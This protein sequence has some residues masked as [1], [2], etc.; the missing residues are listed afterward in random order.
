MNAN[1]KTLLGNLNLFNLESRISSGI[2]NRVVFL[3]K[4]PMRKFDSGL[5]KVRKILEP[6]IISAKYIRLCHNFVKLNK[7]SNILETTGGL[8]SRS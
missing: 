2:T 5:K 8:K 4:F 6:N 7:I 3:N 1:R